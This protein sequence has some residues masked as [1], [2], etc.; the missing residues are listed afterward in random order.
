MNEQP[1]RPQT[2]ERPLVIY[3]AGCWDGFCAAWLFHHAFPDAEFVPAHHGTPPPDVTGLDVFIVDFSYK[4]P[5]ML[6]ICIAAKS[7]TVLDHHKTAEADLNGL[8]DDCELRGCVRPT[9]VFDMDKSG[10][11]LAWE[12][13]QEN[14]NGEFFWGPGADNEPEAVDPPWIV[15]YTEDRD[16]WRWRLPASQA[17]NAAIRSYPLDFD[18]WDRLHK[19]SPEILANGG[20]AILRREQQIIDQHVRHAANIDIAGHRVPAV[21][22]TVLTSEIVGELA[23]GKPFAVGYFDRH[24][25]KRV[26]SL[27][28]DPDGLDVS[29]IAKAFG[30]GGHKHAAGFETDRPTVTP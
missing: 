4:R 30:G 18:M 25:G 16:L 9:V 23:K 28:S 22:A 5:V 27:R 1:P 10:G 11:R 19:E 7:L 8:D 20:R 26:W 3:H 24:D 13:L 29:E 14:T 12:Y 17:I 21:N 15:D 6:N 2:P